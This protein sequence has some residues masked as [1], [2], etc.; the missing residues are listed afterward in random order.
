MADPQSYRPKTSD[1]P[2]QPG[3]YRFIDAENRVIYVG[4]AKS[5]RS[6]LVNYFQ[7]LPKLHPRTRQMVTTAVRVA[8]VTVASETEALTLEYQ[9]IKE[10]TP[11]FNVIFRDDKS[12]PYLAVTTLEPIPRL[13]G[14]RAAHKKGN[15]YY[16][17][18]TKGSIRDSVD[19]LLKVFPVR[20][21]SKGALLAARRSGRP[22]LNGYIDRCAAPCIGRVS[23]AEHREL[24]GE[25]VRFLDSDGQ[26]LVRE[27]TAAM[28]EAAG[29]E[30]YERAAKLRDEVTALAR[31][32]EKNTVVMAPDVDADV[33]GFEFDELEASVQVFYVRGGRIRGQ[34]G[35]VS[36]IE[37][38]D[39]AELLEEVL[40]HHYGEKT[41]ARHSSKSEPAKNTSQAA[42][43]RA[44]AK[45]QRRSVDD[46]A[47]T[48]LSAIPREIWLPANPSDT[49]GLESWLSELRGGPVH[50]KMPQRGEK[51]AFMQ[52]VHENAA[53]ALHRHKLH[54]C[55]DLTERSAAL[56]ELRDGLGLPRA[57]LRIECFDISH[58]Q[59][60]HQ[61][62]SMVVFEDGLAKKSDYRKFT[63]RGGDGE[64][65]RD[66]TEAM[67]EV[68]RRRF[69]RAAQDKP[70]REP[71]PLSHANESGELLEDDASNQPK[72]FAYKP[73]LVVVDGGLPQVNAAAAVLEELG[74][75]VTVIG[76]AKRLEE[77]WLPGEEFPLI[78]PR[79]SASLRLLQYVRD[80]SHRFAITFH[81]KSRSKA[82]TRSML[83]AVPG[84]GAAK[85]K[86]LLKHFGSLARIKAAT[87]GQLQEVPGI[88]PAMAKQISDFL[89]N[90]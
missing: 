38:L 58:M 74:A 24:V 60:T 29:A 26:Q 18:Y 78:L 45:A 80:E 65:A 8:W 51:A 31:L 77:V 82:M 87:P 57:P 54:R 20:S 69:T 85:Q 17:P 1:I 6:R 11:R 10:F 4:K 76:L 5:L 25:L 9:W 86:A 67:A 14:T 37:A 41:E 64:G 83:D 7:P 62:A 68:L 88:G 36:D 48:D 21:C 63:I 84:L 49:A 19:L 32:V 44:A 47:H 55:T 75:V 40:V 13:L 33:F 3:V 28:R 43:M 90:N 15:K 12:Y 30:E 23:E 53:A 34:R 70:Q 39:A 66:D 42:P 46:V 56:E 71:E 89:A 52:T 27:K 61:V 59:G 79:Q 22:C 2:A 73:D 35:W 50:L 81:R 72:R 16:G